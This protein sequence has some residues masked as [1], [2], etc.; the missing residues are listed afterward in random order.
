MLEVVIVRHAP[1]HVLPDVLLS[2]QLRR[3]GWQPFKLNPVFVLLQQPENGPR[4][5]RLVVV[6]KEDDL[7]FRMS[8]QIIGS[9][10]SCQQSPKAN[11]VPPLMN[12]GHRFACDGVHCTP[13]PTFCRTHT[14]CEDDPLP[15]NARPAAG[16]RREQA[17]LGRVSEEKDLFWTGLSFSVSD[18]FFSLRRG[19]GPAY[20]DP[21]APVAA[22]ANHEP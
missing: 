22:T 9:R 18:L 14:G 13:V 10:N 12:H 5:V 17:H 15:S 7:A 8:S 21:S 6:D 16:D 19:Q 3:V 4:L 11:I 2:V 1:S 20:A